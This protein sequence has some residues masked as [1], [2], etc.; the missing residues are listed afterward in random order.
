VF[1]KEIDVPACAIHA[2]N[3]RLEAMRAKYDKKPEALQALPTL[4][5]FNIEQYEVADEV[6]SMYKPI[7][8]A[9]SFPP[10]HKAILRSRIDTDDVDDGQQKVLGRIIINLN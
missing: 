4:T 3:N 10:N 9:D 1:D 7:I 6:L 8:L 5:V 2:Q